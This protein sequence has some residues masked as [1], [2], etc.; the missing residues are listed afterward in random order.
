MIFKEQ[1]EN[2]FQNHLGNLEVAIDGVIAIHEHLRFDNRN[3]PGFLAEGDEARQCMSVGLEASAAGIFVPI[4]IT[5]RHFVKRAPSLPYSAS[6]SRNSSRPSVIVSPGKPAS[7]F[8]PLST[9]IPAR[10]PW[11][12]SA[13]GNGM[14]AAVFWRIVSSNKIAPL[15]KSPSPGVVKSISRYARRFSSVAGMPV[16]LN[17]FSMVGRLSSAA[18]IPLPGATSALAVVSISRGCIIVAVHPG[19]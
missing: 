17:R 3:Q 10:M 13:S 5:A 1:Y 18:R 4:V 9:L 19:S 6:R 11:L 12:L 16:L 8:A 7:G 15:I 14:P 2:A